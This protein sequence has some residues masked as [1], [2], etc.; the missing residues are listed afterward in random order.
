MGE[1]RAPGKLLLLGEY[2]VLDGAPAVVIAVDRFARVTTTPAGDGVW[3]IAAAN[4][5][6]PPA[7]WEANAARDGPF[8]LTL[9]LLDAL[10]ARGALPAPRH[11]R[12]DSAAFYAGG[13]KLG[14]GSSAAVSVALWRALGEP[15]VALGDRAAAFELLHGAHAAH[16]GGR[17]SGVD[18]AA[19]LAG[20][21]TAFQRGASGVSMRTLHLPPDL[22]WLAVDTGAAASTPAALAALDAWRA[23]RPADARARLAA[24]SERAVAGIVALRAR[25]AAAFCGAAADYA[26]EL[27][28][29]GRAAG[30]DI[31]SDRH[32][33]LARRAAAHGVVYKPSGAGGGDLGVALATDPAA[34][35]AFGAAA[36]AS[37]EGKPLKLHRAAGCGE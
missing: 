4:L 25:R 10:A 1:G 6:H 30:I 26:R 8:G 20:G 33:V 14:L 19:A 7:R 12:I 15:G 27:A 24:L 21:V 37:G 13:T 32:R 34:L 11:C 17:G 28:A 2:A 23:R 29:L 16:Q 9:R 31:V 22:H 3:R 35:A 36:A 5:A 18:I